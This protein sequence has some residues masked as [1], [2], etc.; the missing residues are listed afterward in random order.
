MLINTSIN[1]NNINHYGF[2][3]EQRVLQHNLKKAQFKY[4][5]LK[6]PNREVLF[7]QAQTELSNFEDNNLIKLALLNLPKLLKR[8]FT[9]NSEQK[10]IIKLTRKMFDS[11]NNLEFEYDGI[12]Y[13]YDN[14][15]KRIYD[16]P[17]F[18]KKEEMSLVRREK[19]NTIQK[20]FRNLINKRN[21]FAKKNGYDNY[22]QYQLEKEYGTTE[23]EIDKIIDK[24][25]KDNNVLSL[26]KKREE[27]IAKNNKLTTEELTSS[28]IRQPLYTSSSINHYIKSQ[29][30]L[31]DLVKKCY[32]TMGYNI[33]QLEKEDHLTLDLE[34]NNKKINRTFC[35][36]FIPGYS[37]GI[38]AKMSNDIE[39]LSALMH[40]M[41]HGMHF[42][43]PFKW[44]P[45]KL[46]QPKTHITEAIALLFESLVYKENL[47]EKIIPNK[48]VVEKF[49]EYKALDEIY[50]FSL[51]VSRTQFEK[52]IYKHP[53]QDFEELFSKIEKQYYGTNKRRDWFAPHFINSPGYMQ[54]YIRG[55]L[56]SNQIY[57]SARKKLGTE[58]HSNPKTADFMNKRIFGLGN[59][60]NDKN[61]NILLNL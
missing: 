42:L 13:S 28:H 39:S 6:T 32:T 41:G 16:E 53:E 7:R 11:F 34:E 61:L 30:E 17:D 46:M 5:N 10:E 48:N 3:K 4:N 51:L 23:A 31:I 27:I 35:R 47:L 40:E 58:L 55:N 44:L 18:S 19:L 26:I 29:E 25:Y 57:D 8:T 22:Y 14:F 36:P 21:D 43:N 52:E 24:Y 50:H 9:T 20:D 38:C 56:L 45:Y 15:N 12:K 60:V 59:L 37:V 33:E 54:N 2:L 49:K 1:S